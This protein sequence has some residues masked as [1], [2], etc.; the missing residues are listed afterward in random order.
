M[1][2]KLQ[3]V[4]VLVS[5]LS[6]AAATTVSIGSVSA[7]GDM[8]VDSHM[9]KGT[10]TLFDGS[11]VETKEATAD[12]RLAK[13]AEI[14]MSAGSRGTLHSDGLELQQGESELKASSSFILEAN[15]LQVTPNEQNS[16]GVVSMRAGNTVEVSAL[17]GSFGVARNGILLASVRPGRTVSFA[18]QAGGSPTSFSGSGIITSEN[19]HY[20]I[21]S[22]VGVKYE[23]TC[24]NLSKFVGTKAN[25]SG[26]VQAPSGQGG[27]G[28]PVVC[29]SSAGI[30]G[31]SGIGLG[32]ALLISGVLVGAGVGVGVSVYESNKS[33]SPASR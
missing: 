16:R 28:V 33:S 29:A 14:R 15:G 25:I 17:N 9:V 7:R 20:Y 4:A 11:V 27:S 2:K 26:T 1:L 22:E 3:V 23:V 18:M 24:K 13:G 8:R 30:H 5:M 31:L 32:K 6:Y 12:L 10:A 19:G 21:T